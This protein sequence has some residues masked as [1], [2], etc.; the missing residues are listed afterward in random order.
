MESIDSD[1][2]SADEEVSLLNDYDSP[3]LDKKSVSTTTG[4]DETEDTRSE[5]KFD[6][7][8]IDFEAG[9]DVLIKLCVILVLETESEK[10]KRIR[11]EEALRSKNATLRTWQQLAIEDYGLVNGRK[12]SLG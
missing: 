8:C 3:N 11:I 9:I 4:F 6:A 2:T 12:F 7:G 5:L 1:V 10:E